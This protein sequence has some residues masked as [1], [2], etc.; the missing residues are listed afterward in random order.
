[1]LIVEVRFF[2]DSVFLPT[3]LLSIFW[4][5]WCYLHAFIIRIR[6]I[7]LSQNAHNRLNSVYFLLTTAANFHL[8]YALLLRKPHIQL[9][10]LFQFFLYQEV[11]IS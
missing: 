8:V 5:F 7:Q 10:I 3:F 4:L 6:P 1:M 11:L 2:W 9:R